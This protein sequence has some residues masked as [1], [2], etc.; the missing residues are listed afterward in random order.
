MKIDYKNLKV[1]PETRKRI[2][3]QA[4]ARDKQIRDH[5]DDL[6]RLPLKVFKKEE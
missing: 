2:K 1:R 3:Q 4:S 6:S 5:V